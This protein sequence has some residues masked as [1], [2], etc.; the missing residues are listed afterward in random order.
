VYLLFGFVFCFL[1]FLSQPT[2]PTWSVNSLFNTK[3]NKNTLSATESENSSAISDE[4]L[5]H[6]FRLAQLQPPTNTQER[7]QLTKDMDDL[8]NFIHSIQQKD[9]GNTAPMTHVWQDGT[10]MALRNDD[11][12]SDQSDQVKGTALLNNAKQTFTP[13][14]TVKGQ[15]QED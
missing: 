9:F 5:D 15:H 11:I 13:F 1:F 7:I 2:A 6:L 12:I 8:T 10:G 3:S 14:Y 4:Q